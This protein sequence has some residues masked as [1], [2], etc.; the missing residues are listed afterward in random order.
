MGRRNTAPPLFFLLKKIV[1]KKLRLILLLSAVCLCSLQLS[2]ITLNGVEYNIDTLSRFSPGPGAMY[3]QL[4][5][6]RAFD[7]ANRLDCW[8][9]TVDT[10][11]PYVSIEAVMGKDAVIGTERPSS[12]AA[13]KTTPTKIF[14][15]G[16]NGDFFATSGDIG[17][18]TGLTIVNNEFVYTPTSATRR[19]GGVGE[20]MLGI[21]GTT[22]KY[23]G[24][25]VLPDTTLTIK[26]VNYT[27]AA[28]QLVL[29][30]QHNGATTLTNQYGTELLIELLPGYQWHTTGTVKA[31]VLTK[32]VGVGSMPIPA[33]KAVLSGH[34]TMQTCLN[35]VNE[36]DTVTVKLSLTIDGK[37]LNMAQCIG[38]DSYALIVDSGRVEQSNFWNELHPRTGYGMTQNADTILF[39]VVDGRG[40]S[41]G[42]TTKV[43]GEIMQYYG[44]WKAVNFDGGGSSCLYLRHFGEVNHGSD[45]N[46]RAVGNAIFAVANIP[47]ADNIISSIT[48]YE[49]DYSLPRFGLAKPK[50]LGYNH[51]GVLLDTDVQNVTLSCDSSLGE[52]LP[53]GRFFASGT[54]SG[55]LH[56]TLNDSVSCD[57]NIRLM[58]DAPIAVRLD[59]LLIDTK[60][61]YEV[62]INGMVGNN[63]IQV[64][65]AAL[66]WTS[67][68]EQVASVSDEGV[69]TGVSNGVTQVAGQFGSYTDT[70]QVRVEIP[71]RTPLMW[72]D[73]YGLLGNDWI[74]TATAGFDPTFGALT[75]EYAG[76][77]CNFNYVIGRSPFIRM[78]NVRLMYSLPD[79]IRWAFSTSAVISKVSIAIRPSTTNQF[80]LLNFTPGA[81]GSLN[82]II[83]PVHETFG[84]DP[85]IYPLELDYI[86]FSVDTKTSTGAHSIS[87]SPIELVYN[88]YEGSGLKNEKTAVTFSKEL[89]NGMLF[90]VR[91]G[92]TYT[93]L[94]TQVQ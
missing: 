29:Y 56:A 13:R 67:L 12:M 85:A 45:G 41:V 89:R 70:L 52:I 15:G 26:H 23:S 65:P 3:Y 72:E 78:E 59:S 35:N 79:T 39:L 73:F 75:G 28:D 4:R 76:V 37:K 81:V 80:Q 8:L 25:L 54:Q 53:D 32:Q 19:F 48:A 62:E 51:Y 21:V 55:L 9:M 57:L 47:E 94:G 88:E 17:R 38:G 87:I 71:E 92:V 90:L 40:V 74:V 77:I 64:L 11:N 33:G 84:D 86:N 68:D 42:C 7:N 50:F 44:A 24:K 36:G 20:D 31:K 46:E 83:I 63:I 93:V 58:L 43:L 69:I 49:T 10:R 27:R 6:R 82:E 91:D 1:M 34:G 16:T 18:P 30:N 14:Y 22:M 2:A 66:T 61:P 60:H 5:M